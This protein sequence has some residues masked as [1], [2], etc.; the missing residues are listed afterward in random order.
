MRDPLGHS[1]PVRTGAEER[2][3]VYRGAALCLELK[4]QRRIPDK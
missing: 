1:I 2:G 4:G 3:D